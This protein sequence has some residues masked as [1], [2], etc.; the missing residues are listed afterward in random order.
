MD[1]ELDI[2]VVRAQFRAERRRSEALAAENALLLQSADD[3]KLTVADRAV[4]AAA[5]A[6]SVAQR[7]ALLAK[8]RSRAAGCK[9]T[10]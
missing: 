2:E 1:F 6:S 7:V 9:R 5:L 10:P 4:E 3:A 8:A